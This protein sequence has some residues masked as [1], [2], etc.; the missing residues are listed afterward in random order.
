MLKSA[1]LLVVPARTNPFASRRLGTY[2]GLLL[3]MPRNS[4]IRRPTASIASRKVAEGRHS[5]AILD[6]E[7]V[8]C[9]S[10]VPDVNAIVG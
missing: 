8:R 4:G 1:G 6:F 10:K 2:D 7:A 9:R 5:A 3:T